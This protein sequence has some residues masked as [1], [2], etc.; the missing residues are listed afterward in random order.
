MDSI[1]FMSV[2]TSL[3]LFDLTIKVS[4][5]HSFLHLFNTL[6]KDTGEYPCVKL[7]EA[8]ISFFF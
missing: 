3:L 2:N 8:K 4:L 5:Q 1:L 7:S 6:Y